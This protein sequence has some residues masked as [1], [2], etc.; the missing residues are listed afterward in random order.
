MA[1]IPA[2]SPCE[3]TS[4]QLSNQPEEVSKNCRVPTATEF[5][6]N[7]FAL[8][9]FRLIDVPLRELAD[10]RQEQLF[11]APSNH[12]YRRASI[13]WRRDALRAG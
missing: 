9:L 1:A 7:D 10:G 4:G 11:E 13:G 8:V 2:N 5:P 6:V 3:S 12:S